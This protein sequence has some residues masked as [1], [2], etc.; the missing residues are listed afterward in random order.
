MVQTIA[1][2]VFSL[3]TLSAALAVV[4]GRNLFH[5]AL[6]LNL[7]FIG[8]AGLYILLEA[9]FLAG[10]QILIYVGAIAILIVFAIMLTHHIMDKNLI[11]RNTQ[12]GLSVLAVLLLFGGLCFILLH[13]NW[14]LLE[15]AVP[16]KM[17]SM[18]GQDLL[19]TYLIPFE[20]ASVLLLVALLGSIVIAR[21]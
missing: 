16:E 9:P 5:S 1:F 19:D 21:E 18:L 17:I 8:V 3:V 11:Q 20:A 14:P 2:I 10:V 4:I 13:T 6:F 12:W 7:S 15:A